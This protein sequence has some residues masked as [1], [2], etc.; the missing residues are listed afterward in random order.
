MIPVRNLIISIT[1]KTT[2]QIEKIEVHFKVSINSRE[3][4]VLWKAIFVLLC[5]LSKAILFY[6]IVSFN[7]TLVF[8]VNF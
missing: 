7:F 6:F 8:L 2:N 1:K 4:F 5:S 3:V